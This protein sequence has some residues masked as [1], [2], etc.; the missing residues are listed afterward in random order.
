MI[1]VKLGNIVAAMPVVNKLYFMSNEDKLSFEAAEKLNNFN[2]GSKEVLDNYNS[3]IIKIADRFGEIVEA[4]EE[5]ARVTYIDVDDKI[6]KLNEVEKFNKYVGRL[7]D[8][9]VDIIYFFRF[10]KDDFTGTRGLGHLD[11]STLQANELMDKD[12]EEI[13][14]PKQ[15]ISIEFDEED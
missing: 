13:I 14:K 2:K 5:D 11:I 6:Y 4:R 9:Q 8:F 15:D 7:F 12:P 3:Q 10:N 1:T